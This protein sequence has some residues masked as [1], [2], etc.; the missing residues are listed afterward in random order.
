MPRLSDMMRADFA[1]FK[2]QADRN[3]EKAAMFAL[4]ETRRTL[5]RPYPPASKRGE[6]PARRRGVLQAGQIV[7]ANLR[8]GTIIFSNDTFYSKF[9]A[10]TRPWVELTIERINAELAE[11]LTV[12]GYREVLNNGR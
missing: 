9:L 3:L 6:A 8:S 4:D 7:R 10:P 11:M 2:R 5:D 1:R 12:R